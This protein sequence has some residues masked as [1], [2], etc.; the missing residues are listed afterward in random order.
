MKRFTTLLAA[1]MSAMTVLAQGRTVD[2]TLKLRDFTEV[3]VSSVWNVEIEQGAERSV[4]LTYSEELK[5][6]IVAETIGGELEL[7]LDMDDMPRKLRN[8]INDAGY[9]GKK[10]SYI[11]TA[12]IVTPDLESIE[13]SG[14][15][16][17][18]CNGIFSPDRF[19]VDLSGAAGVTGLEVSVSS[20]HLDVS[21]AG[22]LAVPYVRASECDMDFSGAASVSIEGDIDEVST[23]F[24][25]ASDVTLSGNYG[26]VNL[27]ASGACDIRLS[28][29]AME[30]RID[31]SG[32]CSIMARELSVPEVFADG[33]GASTITVSPTSEITIDISGATTLRYS[34]GIDTKIISVS[35]G[36]SIDTF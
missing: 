36:C 18:Q 26:F 30:L 31:A 12:R 11:L 33:S 4:T 23:D 5:P 16:D 20:L 6:Y 17:I 2:E 13:A 9:N 3:E 8:R 25:G 10:G 7:S 14:A 35:R 27:D 19:S 29:K 32:A 21:G 1:S 22:R 28:G 15:A 34:K 24:S